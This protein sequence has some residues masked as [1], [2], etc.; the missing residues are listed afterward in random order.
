MIYWGCDSLSDQGWPPCYPELPQHDQAWTSGD[1][2]HPFFYGGDLGYFEP[3]KSLSF[4]GGASLTLGFCMSDHHQDVEPEKGSCQF[5]TGSFPPQKL[6]ECAW[7][8]ESHFLPWAD[9]AEQMSRQWAN[10]CLSLFFWF[11][12]LSGQPNWGDPR[13]RPAWR[14]CLFRMGSEPV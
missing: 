5:G 12:T 3:R 4:P 8:S 1:P 2:A 11:A 10:K 7:A 14:G 6:T 9:N 13:P